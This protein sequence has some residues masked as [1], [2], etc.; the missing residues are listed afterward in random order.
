MRYYEAEH[1]EG[2]ARVKA[3]QLSQWSD[4]HQ[5]LAGFDDFPNRACLDRWLPPVSTGS[6][7]RVLEYGCGT[8]PAACFLA[9]RSYQVTG[10]DLVQ[11][12]IDLARRHATE[13]NVSVRFQVEDICRWNEDAALEDRELFDVVLDSYCLQSI[14]IDSDRTRV[15]AGVRRRLKPDGR[16]LLSTAMFE[17]QRDYGPDHY[18]PETGIVWSPTTAPME[19]GRRIGSGWYLPHRRHLTPAALRTELEGFGFCIIEQS[20]SGGDVVCVVDSG[21]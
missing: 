18:D 9:A 21:R 5:T 20:A 17:P 10:I 6:R 12:A 11:D 19:D 7:V 13:Q 8:G 2:Y 16:Y 3:D 14:V 15:I 4:L 1:V